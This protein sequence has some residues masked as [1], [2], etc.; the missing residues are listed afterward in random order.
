MGGVDVHM[1]RKKIT[2][3]GAKTTPDEIMGR[4]EATKPERDRQCKGSTKS[5]EAGIGKLKRQPVEVGT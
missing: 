5:K 1:W 2:M 4:K 3:I